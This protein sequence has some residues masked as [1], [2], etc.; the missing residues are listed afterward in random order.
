MDVFC[1]GFEDTE[2]LYPL[3]LHKGKNKG[4]TGRGAVMQ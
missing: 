4:F 2:A 3:N 1:E